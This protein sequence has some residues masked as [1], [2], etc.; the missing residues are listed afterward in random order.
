MADTD[1][2]SERRLVE[3]ALVIIDRAVSKSGGTPSGGGSTF[4]PQ[5]DLRDYNDPSHS[6]LG[7]ADVN[8]R[9]L[10]Q[11]RDR[12]T[13]ALSNAR[14]ADLSGFDAAWADRA[15]LEYA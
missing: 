14:G 13:R 6:Y 10:I 1:Y 5:P 12:T 4:L 15:N 8:G 7:W 11:R 9:W 3:A 2:I